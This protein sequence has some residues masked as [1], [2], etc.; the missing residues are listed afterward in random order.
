MATSLRIEGAGQ[1]AGG[2]RRPRRLVNWQHAN[3][4]HRSVAA[5][6]ILNSYRKERGIEQPDGEA[7]E[8]SPERPPAQP[9]LVFESVDD[10][11]CPAECVTEVFT[12]DEMKHA[13]L[14]AKDSLV[15]VDFY[16]TACGACKYIQSGFVKLC[17]AAYSGEEP[18]VVFLKHNVFDDEEEE[19][20]E[21]AK[22]LDIKNV[23]L[24]Q[25]YRRG[26]MLEQFATRDKKR[27]GEAINKYTEPGMVDTEA[28][29]S[30]ELASAQ[31]TG[32]SGMR[33]PFRPSLLNFLAVRSE[34]RG[35][36]LGVDIF[37][38]IS[39]THCHAEL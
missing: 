15:I 22:L 29:R 32:G 20:T 36:V 23:P 5:C 19:T 4:S 33:V 1:C 8:R 27:I 31:K 25:F 2:A 9:L 30:G 35:C 17:K 7:P 18:Q 24:F 16:K 10:E 38:Q 6:G 21:L 39:C 37:V 26:K 13:L 28:V 3:A 14:D 11:T 34:S 12:K